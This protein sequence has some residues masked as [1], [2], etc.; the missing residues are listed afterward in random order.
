MIRL[1]LMRHAKS[2][3]KAPAGHDIDR[4]LNARGRRSAALLGAWLRENVLVPDHALVSAAARTRETWERLAAVTGPLP[5]T[6]LPELYHAEPDVFLRVLRAA[7]EVPCLLA[8]GHQ[9]GI[10]ET[11]RRLLADPPASDAF[12]AYPTA[13]TSGIDF[14]AASAA[15]I[16]WGR[17]RLVHFVTPRGLEAA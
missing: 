15:G 9:P 10:G 12:R 5:V 2:S 11:A 16:D 8:L 17:G 7:P 13:A 4:A 3:W 6:L 1:I 14:E